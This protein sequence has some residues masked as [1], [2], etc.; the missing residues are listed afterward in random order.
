MTDLTDLAVAECDR[1]HS[2]FKML[3]SGDI[4]TRDTLS[5]AV[6]ETIGEA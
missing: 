3:S 5:A 1:F 2:T 6:F 4:R